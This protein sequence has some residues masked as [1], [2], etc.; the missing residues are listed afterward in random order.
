M[1]YL[2]AEYR[3]NEEAYK[4]YYDEIEVCYKA[5]ETHFKSAI[6]VRNHEMVDRADLIIC[7]V[8]KKSGGAYEAVKY[9]E[10]M[11]KEIINLAVDEN[12]F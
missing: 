2:S 1:P 11:H 12:N 6:R 5:E 7:Y 9:A 10:K 4:N 3:N 8:N